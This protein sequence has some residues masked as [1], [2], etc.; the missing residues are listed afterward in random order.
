MVNTTTGPCPAH[1]ASWIALVV[2]RTPSSFSTGSFSSEHTA[3]I[4]ERCPTRR[5]AWA[6][7]ASRS[8]VGTITRIR[9]SRKFS[10]AAH[11][12][13]IVFPEPVADTPVPRSP[14]GARMTLQGIPPTCGYAHSRPPGVPEAESQT[15]SEIVG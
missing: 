2:V 9:Q 4:G 3:T 1:R 15:R 13:V 11:A 7:C 8:R 12:A 14:S 6:V 10:S 5:H